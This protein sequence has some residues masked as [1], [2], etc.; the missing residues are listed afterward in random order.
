MKLFQCKNCGQVLY[1]ENIQCERCGHRLGFSAM[2]MDLLTLK[3]KEDETYLDFSE[4]EKTYRYCDNAKHKACNWILPQDS[5][6]RLCEACRLN[7]TI[8]DLNNE[9][10][11]H[12]W[13]KLEIAKHRLLY[14]LLRL[15]LPIESKELNPEN[16][17][18]F[19]FLADLGIE[20]KPVYTGHKLGIITVNIEEADDVKRETQRQLMKEPLR[21]LLGHFRHEIGHYYW[22]RLI[23][24]S[25]KLE[26]F[27]RLFGDDTQDYQ[28]A[29]EQYYQNGADSDWPSH[30]ISAYATSHPWEDW[31]ETWAHYLHMID[32]LETG[33][34]FGMRVRPQLSKAKDLSA[35]LNFDPY[36]QNDFDKL[37]KNW[38]PLTLA[39]NSLNRSMGEADLYPFIYA[40]PILEK[41]R[42]V[43]HVIKTC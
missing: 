1:F 33:Y 14:A 10:W 36:C 2:K 35:K 7:H 42:F 5:P 34:V 16:G 12:Y 17:L 38:L 4:G 29:L 11:L 37:I 40:P 25:D 41:L 27:R 8:P 30:Y 31:A 26:D 23:A 6:H 18:G 3:D 15:K 22:S 9:D 24:N 21:T 28:A 32:T 13:Q 39:A 19:E 20:D 43:H